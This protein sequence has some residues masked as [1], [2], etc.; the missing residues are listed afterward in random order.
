MSTTETARRRDIVLDFW[1][2]V[3]VL[4][5]ILHHLVYFRYTVF[6]EF[7]TQ[8]FDAALFTAHNTILIADRVL[9]EFA[10]RSGPLG[11]KIF[12]V[13]SGYII[14][15][16][17]L[18]E[19]RSNG[20]INVLQF[21]TRRIFRILPA[22]IV[23][24]VGVSAVALA[25]WIVFDQRE[26]LPAAG[27]LCN[28]SIATCGTFVIHTWSLAIEEQFY[29][30]WPF[31][32]ILVP[33]VIRGRSLYGLIAAL[34][35]LSAFGVLTAYGWID[36]A[37]SFLC[38]ALG[39]LY[40]HEKPF[41]RFVAQYAWQTIAAISLTAVLLYF[42]VPSSHELVH[43]TYR[44]IQPFVILAVLV[45]SYRFETMMRHAALSWLARVGLMSFS[46]YLWQQ[47]FTASPEMYPAYSP[48]QWPLLMLV[49]AFAS[50]SYIEKP[51]IRWARSA[52]K[53]EAG[54]AI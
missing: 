43:Q 18:E 37:L 21:Y 5:V 16:I 26:L 30:V 29:L 23:Y 22:Y 54:P 35:L 13:I 7:A 40:A 52:L 31:L 17:L 45:H 6:K 39:A 51:I 36:S 53:R 27:F 41:E 49:V 3:S 19:T 1:R 2:G 20:R 34:A 9:V 38:I 48:L 24:L 42:A 14:T 32:F 50:Y 28:T 15:K 44:L 10:E 8:T 33:F 4:L 25:G 11:V 46:L 12:F 47:L